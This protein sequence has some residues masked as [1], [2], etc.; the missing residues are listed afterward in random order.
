MLGSVLFGIA[1]FAGLPWLSPTRGV[2]RAWQGSLRALEK[3][4]LEAFDAYLDVTYKDGFGLDRA[5]AVSLAKTMR[6]H[7]LICTITR[8]SI[9]TVLAPGSKSAAS[10]AIIRLGG[11]GSPVATAAIQASANSH[12]PTLFRWR[13]NSWQPWDWKLISVDNSDAARAVGQFQRDA[14]SFGLLP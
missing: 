10:R 12:S 14:G 6:S 3:N 8:E 7:F 5:G 4:N 2:E 13:R 9:E 11:Q 1:L